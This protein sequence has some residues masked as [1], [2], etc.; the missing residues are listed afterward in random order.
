M[1]RPC[2]LITVEGLGTNLLGCYGGAVSQTPNIDEF[3]ASSI[4]FDQCWI[5]SLDAAET[6]RSMLIGASALKHDVSCEEHASTDASK[7]FSLASLLGQYEGRSRFVSD[8]VELAEQ[9]FLDCFDDV[10]FV[11]FDSEAITAAD[12]IEQTR[13]AKLIQIAITKLF[14]ESEDVVELGLLWIH[15][16]GLKTIWDAP[17]EL[18]TIPCDE[19][20]PLPSKDIHPPRRQLDEESNPD[21]LFDAICGASA[22]AAVLDAAWTYINQLIGETEDIT[23][24]LMGT[25]GYPLGEHESIGDIDDQ[26]HAERLHVPLIIR[27]TALPIGTRLPQ[28]EQPWQ[29][30]NYI[31]Q[32]LTRDV[33]DQTAFWHQPP[34]LSIDWPAGNRIAW[35]ATDNEYALICPSWTSRV[36]MASKQTGDTNRVDLSADAITPM[37][38]WEV[39]VNP[40]DR[41]QQNDIA[42]R[43]EPVVKTLSEIATKLRDAMYGTEG[44]IDLATLNSALESLLTD[45]LVRLQ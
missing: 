39:F 38:L 27:P 26:L 16:K 36:M 4:V 40:D 28:I 35:A 30:G 5:N 11:D 13:I 31:E 2:I 7:S 32:C 33:A 17:Y 21:F 23:V 45:D 19:D 37:A 12:T 6:I 3:A 18:R 25:S 8:A 20:D 42:D 34:A 9:T 43:V 41:F 44:R 10:D 14:E 1:L 15:C 24:V 22:Q 29:V